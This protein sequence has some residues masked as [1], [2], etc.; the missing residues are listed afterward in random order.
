MSCEEVTLPP[1]FHWDKKRGRKDATAAIRGRK[2]M[3]LSSIAMH[4]LCGML[5]FNPPCSGHGGT[6]TLAG[7]PLPVWSHCLSVSHTDQDCCSPPADFFPVKNPPKPLF[8]KKKPTWFQRSNAL[9][10]TYFFSEKFLSNSIS[11]GKSI[12][13]ALNAN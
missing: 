10:K 13:I 8:L 2:P 7:S 9:K 11:E 1:E 5:T 4:T 3:P 6:P 12:F